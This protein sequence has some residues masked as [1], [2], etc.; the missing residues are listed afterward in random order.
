M[1][2]RVPLPSSV[3]SAA[4][5]LDAYLAQLGSGEGAGGGAAAATGRPGKKAKKEEESETPAAAA[6]AAAAAPT[7]STAAAAEPPAPG[8]KAATSV[9]SAAAVVESLRTFFD[10]ALGTFLLYR[11][12]RPQYDALIRD[13]KGRGESAAASSRRMSQVRGRAWRA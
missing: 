4:S 6:A 13:A 8:S 10:R 1:L 12:E 2:L 7:A 11:F 9:A 5:I 3:P